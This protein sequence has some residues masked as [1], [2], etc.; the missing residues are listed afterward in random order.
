MLDICYVGNTKNKLMER[1]NGH[2]A[3]LRVEDENKSAYH[4]KKDG[5]KEEDMEVVGLEHV[6]RAT[7]YSGS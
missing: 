7:T 4:F 5:H 3:D 2:K 1:F 6:P